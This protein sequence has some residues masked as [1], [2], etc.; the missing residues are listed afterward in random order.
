MNL[1]QAIN[2]NT[3]RTTPGVWLCMSG[4]VCMCVCMR[5]VRAYVRAIMCACNTHNCVS[6][7]TRTPSNA[8]SLSDARTHTQRVEQ[9]HAHVVLSAGVYTHESRSRQPLG[10]WCRPC[11]Q[12]A[13]PRGCHGRG[14]E[15]P[16][17]GHLGPP[18]L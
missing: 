8:P 16:S 5:L 6:E 13:P 2:R 14:T 15:S 4:C 7:K 1:T 17:R 9:S 11:L 18:A 10:A 12:N 3:V